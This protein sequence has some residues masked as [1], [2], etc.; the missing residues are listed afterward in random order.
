VSDQVGEATGAQ[1]GR[2]STGRRLGVRL[3]PLEPYLLMAPAAAFLAVFLVWPA[4]RALLIAFQ[5]ASGNFTLAN[6]QQMLQEADFRL[7]LRDTF[8]LLVI[9]I[10]LETAVALAMAVLAQSRLRG[11]GFF[12]YVWSLPL[13]IS[14]LAA[15]LVWLSIFTQH[16]YLNSILQDLHLVQHPVGFLDY[17]NLGGL[18]LS[19]V[20]AETWRSISLVMVIVLSGIQGIPSDLG[21]AAEMLGASA[22]RRFWHVTL[23]LLKPTL[24]VAL[25]LRTTAAFQVFAVVLVLTGSAFPV[26]ATKAESWVYDYR[27]YQMAAVYA[28]LLLALS[29]LSTLVY[30]TT[31][32]TPRAVFGR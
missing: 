16:G 15:G 19:V 24:Q 6:F 25:I 5:S 27:N 4:V 8:L 29:S 13:A 11:R 1:V 12:L 10:P 17:N 28:I 20:L 3:R 23:P 30:L 22:W 26:L 14:D 18:V 7:A 21:E 2:R 32:R 9:V 31:L